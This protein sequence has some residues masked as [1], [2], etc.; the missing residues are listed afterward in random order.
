MSKKVENAETK[1]DLEDPRT[2]YLKKLRKISL[3]FAM[4]GV[5]LIVAGNVIPDKW[6]RDVGVLSLVVIGISAAYF[7]YYVHLAM[8]WGKEEFFSDE[9][10][11]KRPNVNDH[12][13]R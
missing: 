12:C 5:L 1:Y 7:F 10:D 2:K 8:R 6:V 4:L 9:N 3:F 11:E 13:W